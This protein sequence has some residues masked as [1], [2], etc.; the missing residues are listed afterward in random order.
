[1]KSPLNSLNRSLCGFACGVLSI[2]MAKSALADFVGVEA[3]IRSDLTICEDTDSPF[4]EVPLAVCDVYAVFDDPAD[5]L[6]SVGDSGIGT[7]DPDGFFQH[8]FGGDTPISCALHVAFPDLRCDS[9]VTIGVGCDD[10]TDGTTTD[11]PDLCP[12]NPEWPNCIGGWFNANPPNGQGD[13]GTYPDLRVLV[14]QLSMAEGENAYGE[15][16]LYIWLDEEVVE[17]SGQMFDCQA[18]ACPGSA[19]PADVNGD[20]TVGAFDLATLLGAWGPCDNGPCRCLDADE[21][22]QI[23]AA[24]LAVLLGTWGPCP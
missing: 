3:E 5:R 8:P 12:Y 20:G 4:I 24:D 23:D 1:M 7:T 9:F 19:C 21:D 13:A 15:I 22:Q 14:A 2:A 11:P 10:G 6:L 16:V 17:I 18:G